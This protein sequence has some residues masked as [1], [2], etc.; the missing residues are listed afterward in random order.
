MATRDLALAQGAYDLGD[1][2]ASK[3]AHDT[4]SAT[5]A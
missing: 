1:V 4:E 2:E 5:E 3:H